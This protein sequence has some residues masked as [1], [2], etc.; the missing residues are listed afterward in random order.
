VK[1]L[2][3]LLL[4]GA[5]LAAAFASVKLMAKFRPEAVI[6]EKTRLFTTVE[7]LTV[8]RE[9]VALQLPTQGIIE[10]ARTTNLATEVAGRVVEVS[11]RFEIGERFAEGDLLVQL[12][13]ADYRA[14]LI[15]AEASLAEAKAALVTEQ[16]RAE[17]SERDW[18]KLGS[19]QPASE[20][21]LRKPQLASAEARVKATSGALEQAQRNLERTRITAPFAGRLRTKNTEVGSFLNP[22]SIIA[23]FTSIGHYRVRLPLSVQDLNFLP[24]IG[25]PTPIPVKLRAEA[26]GRTLSW[27][28]K[29]LRTEGEVERA[30][31]SVYLVADAQENG[32]D[33]I[34]Q[35]GLFVHAEVA[36]QTL[37][38]VFRIPRSAFLDQDRVILVDAQNRLRFQQVEIIRADGTDLL[39]SSGL[40]DGDRVCRTSLSS[41]SDG[42]E[43]RILASD[44]SP[45]AATP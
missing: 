44:A 37:D 6:V 3:S 39:V 40:K 43:V 18:S 16:A 42:M 2:W 17:Q 8:R 35:P 31:R 4:G 19:N 25:G 5:L 15:Q 1:I 7:T 21:V 45:T 33:D 32:S 22:G 9:K 20:L 27:T 14:A 34:L 24:P 36:G 13:D 38:N 30:S 23:E 28:G 26:A 11:P 12:E 10:A 41:P 29:V